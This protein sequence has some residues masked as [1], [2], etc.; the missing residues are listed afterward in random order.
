MIG[1]IELLS[2]LLIAALLGSVI[3]FERE[4]LSWAAGLRTHMLVCVG[5]AL[6]MLVSAFGFADVLGQKNVVLDPS[7]VAAQVV[8]GIGF[9]GAGSILLRG[10]VVRGLTTAA[11]LWSV[12][13]IG[14]AVGGGMYTAAIGATAIILLILAGVKPLERRFISVR[15]QRSIQLLAERGSV[16]LD[17]VHRALG[18]GSVRVKQFIVQQSED[19]A[20]LDDVQIALSRVAAAEYT[21]ICSRLGGMAGVR[22]CR[23]DR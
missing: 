1:N 15:Q 6:M 2:R 5:A 4:R 12:A 23:H 7:R 10:E 3:G 22:E 16:S 21:A 11:S 14:L 8:S 17:S 20:D 13:G 9:L 18:S 19:D